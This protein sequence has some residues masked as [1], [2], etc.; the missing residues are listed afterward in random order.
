[1]IE[2][3]GLYYMAVKQME[4]PFLATLPSLRDLAAPDATARDAMIQT[5]VYLKLSVA[6]TLTIYVTRTKGR[7]WTVRPAW[8]LFLAV[9]GAQLTATVVSYFGVFMAPLPWQWIAVVWGYALAGFLIEDELKVIT[10]RVLDASKSL[11]HRSG[12]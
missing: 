2:S 5:L 12:G 3:F 10:L 11:L 6:G 9:T 4:I 7:F 8:P 1:V